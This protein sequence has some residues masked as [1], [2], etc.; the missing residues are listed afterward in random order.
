MKK[1][2]MTSPW[3]YNFLPIIIDVRRSHTSSI[4]NRS[5]NWRSVNQIR[6]FPY[7][8]AACFLTKNKTD[9]VHEIRF[10]WFNKISS[11]KTIWGFNKGLGLKVE[12]PYP[13]HLSYN[14]KYMFCLRLILYFPHSNL[15]DPFG[16]MIAV[17]LL[18]GIKIFPL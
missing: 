15:P 4:S 2:I 7:T 13:S 14:S 11:Q 8:K 1:K 6:Q 9:R 10:A 12:K 18:N 3:I 17:N 5:S 16:P